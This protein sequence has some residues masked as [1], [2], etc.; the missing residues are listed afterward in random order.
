MLSVVARVRFSGMKVD[1]IKP[2]KWIVSSSPM[3]RVGFRPTAVPELRHWPNVL[4]DVVFLHGPGAAAAG[5][6]SVFDGNQDL[7]DRCL[8]LSKTAR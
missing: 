4:R 7:Q 5:F 2:L 1:D 3:V 8:P 6:L